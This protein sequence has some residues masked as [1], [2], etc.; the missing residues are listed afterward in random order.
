MSRFDPSQPPPEPRT[1]TRHELLNKGINIVVAVPP[2]PDI[3]ADTFFCFWRIAERGWPVMAMGPGTAEVHRNHIGLNLLKD[4]RYQTFTHVA[5]L[6]ADQVHRPD[7]VE[8]LARWVL[9]DKSREV[10]AGLYYKRGSTNEPLFRTW[11]ADGQFGLAAEW[12]RKTL[13]RVGTA[14]TG[15]MLISRRVFEKLPFPWFDYVYNPIETWKPGSEVAEYSED[16]FFCLRCYKA[17]VPIYLDPTTEC[18][19]LMSKL[20]THRDY[21]QKRLEHPELFPTGPLVKHP[22]EFG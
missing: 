20:V 9:Q 6:D 3:M 2:P 10:V 4:P 16:T 1:P 19:H 11:H 13:F 14:G 12:Q 18:Y 7:V 8:R 15:I 21:V 17:G 22:A 5:M